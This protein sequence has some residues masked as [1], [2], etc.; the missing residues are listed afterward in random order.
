MQ[1]GP[2]GIMG[3]SAATVTAPETANPIVAAFQPLLEFRV[4]CRVLTV[5]LASLA[6]RVQTLWVSEFRC[7]VAKFFAR[8]D[9][10][11]EFPFPVAKL[12]PFLVDGFTGTG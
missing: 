6:G 12:S 8:V 2:A 7:W 3:S 11:E 1:A 4:F 10:T 5:R 9:V